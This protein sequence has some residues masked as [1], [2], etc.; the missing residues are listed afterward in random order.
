MNLSAGTAHLTNE[1]LLS[2]ELQQTQSMKL[3]PAAK[4]LGVTHQTVASWRKAQEAGRLA[5]A[6]DRLQTETRETLIGRL[7]KIPAKE[8]PTYAEG[9]DYVAG[10][11]SDL[12]HDL[13]QITG[14]T[15]APEPNG[16][17][18]PIDPDGP[19]GPE[20]LKHRFLSAIADYSDLKVQE[21]CGLN[22]E[23]VRQYRQGDWPERG[24]NRASTEKLRA[25]IEVHEAVLKEQ[26]LLSG[27]VLPQFAAG[28]ITLAED[29]RDDPEFVKQWPDLGW[30]SLA[31]E[32]ANTWRELQHMTIYDELV[33][34]GYK[35]AHGFDPETASRVTPEDVGLERTE[36]LAA[37]VRCAD[38]DG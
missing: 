13:S 7:D 14:R 3:R 28:L 22:H 36:L 24:P 16:S 8:S 5:D 11:L 2:I 32:L 23:T 12:I 27:E 4:V 37:V 10:R 9:V 20:T 25:M 6:G 18:S 33:W 15:V 30:I 26:S 29:Q 35:R 1:N 34:L 31:D 19:L 17:E 38:S 21:F